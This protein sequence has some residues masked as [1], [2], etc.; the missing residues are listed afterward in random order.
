[1]TDLTDPIS[2]FL[3]GLLLLYIAGLFFNIY[4]WRKGKPNKFRYLALPPVVG[5][6][7]LTILAWMAIEPITLAAWVG[8]LALALAIGVYADKWLKV[9][10]MYKA[11]S[12]DKKEEWTSLWLL[13]L[14]TPLLSETLT[15]VLLDKLT[16]TNSFVLFTVVTL[17][18][19]ITSGLTYRI[20]RREKQTK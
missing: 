13:V 3:T 17:T 11:Y 2:T 8:L 14:T 12:P 6:V 4:S 7:L 19:G 1:M 16:P 18:L 5:L 9:V 20:Y 10:P 15:R